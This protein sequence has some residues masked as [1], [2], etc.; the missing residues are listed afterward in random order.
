[1]A[2]SQVPYP[3]HAHQIAALRVALSEP[4]FKAYLAKGGNDEGYALAL[5]LYN[6]RVAKAFM[7]P[8]GI[9]E[10]TLRNAI[11]RRFVEIYGADWHKDPSVLSSALTVES[12]E[13][14]NKAISRA[15]RN[16]DHGQVVAELTFDFWSNLMRPE[17]RT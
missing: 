3:N 13:A 1:M 14:L 2:E 16:A 7:F 10:V 5:Y 6:I 12:L 15:G 9:V 4:R 8:L 17:Y 11:D